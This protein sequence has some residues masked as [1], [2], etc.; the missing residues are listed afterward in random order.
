M[1]DLKRELKLRGLSIS[2]NKTEL[3][4]RLQ[5]AM[6]TDPILDDAVI[7]ADDLL[8]EDAVLSDEE[9]NKI[10]S[11]CVSVENELLKSPKSIL[12]EQPT[13]LLNTS[14]DSTLDVITGINKSNNNS[15]INSIEKDL[16]TTNEENDHDQLISPTSQTK[17]IVLK[18]K[19]SFCN[20]ITTS[21]NLK[22]DAHLLDDLEDNINEEATKRKIIKLNNHT[23]V[24]MGKDD[25][26][27]KKDVI[28]PKTQKKLSLLSPEE[29]LQMR[30]K[31]FGCNIA[32]TT[33]ASGGGNI[34]EKLS[35]RGVNNTLANEKQLE[36]LKKR[37]E[38]FGC[39]TS[40][41]LAKIDAQEK[42]LKRKERFGLITTSSVTSAGAGN[43]KSSNEWAERAKK[44]LERF[45]TNH[46]ESSSLST[47]AATFGTSK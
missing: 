27:V 35:G 29:R 5:T 14:S 21:N 28:D 30:A 19:K 43:A 40:T 36:I 47:I 34:T 24:T 16:D 13:N 15:T 37:A 38:R 1:A 20:S 31:K 45:S 41:N 9:E 3:Q 18:R 32:N 11:D 26:L 10:L 23:P 46:A 25:L 22:D 2:G 7:C 42:L 6:V 33:P 12:L 4:E 8:D 39:V 17:K 44:R